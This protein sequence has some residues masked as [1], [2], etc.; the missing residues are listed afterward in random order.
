MKITSLRFKNI[1]SLK[2]EWKID[3]SREPFVSSGLFAIVGPTGAGKSTILDAI[4]LALYHQTPRLNDLSPAEKVMTRHTG[5]CLSEVEFEVK[6]KRYRAFWEVR[7]ARNK[8]DGKIQPARVE[9]A[10]VVANEQGDKIIADKVRDKLDSI[11][12]ISG[13]DFGRFTKSMLLAQGGFAAFLNADSGTRAELLEKITGT[14]IYGQISRRVFNRFR[15]EEKKLTSLREKTDTVELF[16]DEFISELTEKQKKLEAEIISSQ[17]KLGQYIKEQEWLHKVKNAQSQ[18]SQAISDVGKARQALDDNKVD[19]ARLASSEPANKLRK[20]FEQQQQVEASLQEMMKQAENLDNDN[21]LLVKEKTRLGQEYGKQNDLLEKARQQRETIENLLVEQVI[22]LDIDI[23]QLDK[24]KSARQ[25]DCQVIQKQLEETQKD[26]AQLLSGIDSLLTERESSQHYLNEHDAHQKLDSSLSLWS[27]QF[28]QRA[29]YQQQI[30]KS[31]V[32]VETLKTE[33][34]SVEKLQLDNQKLIDESIL[35]LKVCQKTFENNQLALETLSDGQTVESIKALYQQY[36]NAQ[37]KLLECKH[38]YQR[39]QKNTIRLSEQKQDFQ[40]KTSEQHSASDIVTK[41]RK[42]YQQQQK[43]LQEIENS[44]KLERQISDLQGYREKL[45]ADE[46]CPLCGST[47]HPAIESYK[48]INTSVTEQRLQ[49]Q[50]QVLE[51]LAEQGK[52]AGENLVTLE[53]LAKTVEENINETLSS[54]DQ[55]A[56]DWEFVSNQLDWQINIT[57]ESI[58]QKIEQAE[59]QKAKAEKHNQAVEKAN[60]E[61]RQAKEVLDNESRQ[62]RVLQSDSLLLNTKKT[63]QLEQHK[64]HTA[65]YQAEIE[66]LKAIDNS[67]GKQLQKDYQ[68]AGYQLPDINEQEIWLQQRQQE[69]QLYKQYK[70]ALEKLSKS[71]VDKQ[72]LQEKVQQQMSDKNAELEKLIE[73]IKSYSEQL[74][75]AT[76]KRQILFGDKETQIERARLINAVNQQTKIFTDIEQQVDLVNKKLDRL[77]GQIK[78]NSKALAKQQ[79]ESQKLLKHWQQELAQSPFENTKCFLDA[80]LDESEQQ[81]LS[82]LKDSIDT[83]LHKC[84]ALQQKA[85]QDLITI[86]QLAMTNKTS[87]Q[88]QIL[89]DETTVSIG[90]LNKQSGE[91]EQRLKSDKEQRQKHQKLIEQLQLQQI[92]YDDWAYLSSLIGSADG[93]KFRVFAQGLTLDYLIHLA[94]MQL[95]QLHARYQLSRNADEVLDLEVIDTWQGDAVRDT[96]TLSGGESFLVS[97]ALALA[98]S[99]LVSHKTRIDSLFLDEGFGTLDRETLDIALDALDNLNASGK[100]IGVIS[101]IEALKERIP[102]QIEI[103]KMSGLGISKLDASY[104]VN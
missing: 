46:P 37:E 65:Q 53:T 91:I 66:N 70:A 95:N 34:T 42:D 99:D 16:N 60:A 72:H 92:S 93:K 103:K 6:D 90:Q 68:Q 13:L 77:Q 8:A 10:E 82:Q 57:D 96:R 84:I 38:L 15:E 36:I 78:Q 27:E 48:T 33:L 50:K 23:A 41:L 7:R 98:L 73:Q 97:L 76:E 104:M 4:C 5:E 75:A 12:E 69:S 52:V 29:K 64:K 102:V 26:S 89:E 9:L 40:K 25:K 71:I 61:V 94:N 87:E 21:T 80:L 31:E 101:H 39:Y 55:L 100:M 67:V 19:L 79:I 86:N 3:F 54:N 81:R 44:L 85:Q 17:K 43:L 45:Q 51:Q 2:G 22:P 20:V 83:Q 47:E 11:V 74:Q 28:K 58:P 56:K 1:N 30:K 63:F 35:R 59:S 18:N 88:L 49:D 62:L 32:V 14:E 24:Q